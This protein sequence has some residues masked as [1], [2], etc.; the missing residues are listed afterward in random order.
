MSQLGSQRCCSCGAPAQVRILHGYD[1]ETPDIRAYC[2]PCA[3]RADRE[4]IYRRKEHASRV[5][6][7]SAMAMLG[8][9][10]EVLAAFVVRSGME[11]FGLLTA[12]GTLLITAMFLRSRTEESVQ[13]WRPHVWGQMNYRTHA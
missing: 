4:A 6:Y 1:G 11:A 9:I 8:L 10:T 3:N 7:A 5:G 12:G 13:A 2:L